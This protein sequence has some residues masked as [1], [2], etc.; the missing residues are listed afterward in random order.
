MDDIRPARPASLV[1]SFS[2]DVTADL[3]GQGR[4][5]PR[6]KTPALDLMKGSMRGC[7]TFK[8]RTQH[9][10]EHQLEAAQISPARAHLTCQLLFS[11]TLTS[12]DFARQEAQ[13]VTLWAVYREGL[14]L[15]LHK[16]TQPGLC[17]PVNVFRTCSI[18]N[19]TYGTLL[20]MSR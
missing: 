15:I 9:A 19:F 16:S 8:T 2:T 7:V 13:G 18:F 4:I 10:T 1:C 6:S 3:D 5:T 12:T 11:F 20:W 17:M 14:V